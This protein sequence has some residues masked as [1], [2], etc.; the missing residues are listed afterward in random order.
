V[1]KHASMGM[2]EL[3]HTH[4]APMDTSKPWCPTLTWCARGT[5]GEGTITIPDRKRQRSRWKICTQTVSAR[6]G[7][8]FEGVRKPMERMVMGGTLLSSGCPVQAIVHASDLDER[9]VADGRDRAGQPC[10][11]VHQAM[12]ERGQWDLIP[13]HADEIGVTGRKRIA[14]MG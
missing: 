3:L 5:M 11:K 4:A 10:Q 6:R 9:T 8:M 2:L 13:V 14:W 12:G 7:T 1:K